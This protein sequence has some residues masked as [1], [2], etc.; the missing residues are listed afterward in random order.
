[1][2]IS[3]DIEQVVL[4]STLASQ[5]QGESLAALTAAALGSMVMA[6][7]LPP[8]FT[9]RIERTTAVE[10]SGAAVRSDSLPRVLARALLG[11]L[12]GRR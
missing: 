4:D 5:G 12:G 9:A 8:N 2:R 7:G 1:M 11:V 6:D 10:L 3:L